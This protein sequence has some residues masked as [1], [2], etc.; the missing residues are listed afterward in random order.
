MCKWKSG[1]KS[2]GGGING[3]KAP[4]YKEYFTTRF[5][6]RIILASEFS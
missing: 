2:I 4:E 6:K 5:E 3:I 1:K